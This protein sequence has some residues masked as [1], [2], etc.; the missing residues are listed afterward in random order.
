M[1]LIHEF[2]SERILFNAVWG[3]SWLRLVILI[4]VLSTEIIKDKEVC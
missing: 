4:Q 3:L 1:S 2:I